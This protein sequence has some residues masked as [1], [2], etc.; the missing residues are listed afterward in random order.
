MKTTK[1]KNLNE[2]FQKLIEITVVKK[3]MSD[4]GRNFLED[5]ALHSNKGG[6]EE[7]DSGEG[8]EEKEEGDE[9]AQRTWID[10]N[11]SATFLSFATDH[12]LSVT[13][14]FHRKRITFFPTATASLS[15]LSPD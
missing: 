4:T 3:L 7:E 15:S 6:K 2:I 1:Y 10:S 8:E 14:C 9:V 11:P 13:L 5:A 12:V